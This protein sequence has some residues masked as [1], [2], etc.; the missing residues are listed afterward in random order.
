MTPG[1]RL[2]GIDPG[3][4]RI[5]LAL[6]DEDAVIASPH[7]TVE[8][9]GLE[10]ALREVAALAAK[11]GVERVV[12]GLPLRLDGS[13]G[14]ASRR[15]RLLADRLGVLTQLPIVLWDERLTTRAAD[16]ALSEAGV[17]GSKRRQVVDRV[18]AALILQSYLDAQ[19]G[20]AQSDRQ[21]HGTDDDEF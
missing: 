8:V 1:M 12:I 3:A 5:G 2:L 9:Q 4:R 17:R 7:S 16:R 15:V 11:L 6:S 19:S 14:E 10:R 13:E 18:A 21:R 20:D